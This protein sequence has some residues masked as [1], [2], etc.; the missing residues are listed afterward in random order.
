MA[1]AP[2]LVPVAAVMLF[3]ATVHVFSSVHTAPA[4]IDQASGERT[5]H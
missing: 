2:V 4:I 5:N 1:V 3:A